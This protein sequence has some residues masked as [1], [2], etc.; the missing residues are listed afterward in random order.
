[1]GS[2]LSNVCR[3]FSREAWLKYEDIPYLKHP[4]VHVRHGRAHAIDPAKRTV[5]FVDPSNVTHTI[6]YDILVLAHGTHRPWP[7]VPIAQ[8]KAQYLEDGDG[9]VT[10]LEAARSVAVVGGGK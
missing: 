8:T 9:F 1:M 6:P 4:S 2:P 3:D 7:N 10:R 5:T